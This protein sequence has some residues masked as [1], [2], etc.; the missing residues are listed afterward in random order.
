MSAILNAHSFLLN[1]HARLFLPRTISIIKRFTCNILSEKDGEYGRFQSIKYFS[2]AMMIAM[3]ASPGNGKIMKQFAL[4]KETICGE[5]ADSD[6]KVWNYVY[7]YQ[8]IFKTFIIIWK[9]LQP[10]QL[11]RPTP[12][13]DC[14][15]CCAPT[16]GVYMYNWMPAFKKSI[17]NKNKLMEFNKNILSI[18]WKL[19]MPLPVYYLIWNYVLAAGK[20]SRFKK[21]LCQRL[22]LLLFQLDV[23]SLKP[24]GTT[25]LLEGGITFRVCASCRSLHN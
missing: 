19:P 18:L 17:M 1:V 12:D 25:A 23:N 14:C 6:S 16:M 5:Y 13:S 20:W 11:T 8:F 21:L 22:L 7:H 9:I 3:K 4:T 15:C 24:F 10:Q 2:F